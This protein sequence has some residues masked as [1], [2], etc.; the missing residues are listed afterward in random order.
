M[1]FKI[2]VKMNKGKFNRFYSLTLFILGLIIII[3]GSAFFRN[4][5]VTFIGIGLLS[6]S[7]VISV[8]EVL[9]NI[10]QNQKI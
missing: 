6:G 9:V 2:Y 4:N 5:L 1:W 8:L 7:I 3:L 10:K